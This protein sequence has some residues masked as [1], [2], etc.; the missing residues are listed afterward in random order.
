MLL[1]LAMVLM[2]STVFAEV[3]EIT[4][5]TGDYINKTQAIQFTV[6]SDTY[7]TLVKIKSSK[8]T[9]G[10]DF[11]VYSDR[12]HTAI[13]SLSA[14]Q[15][16]LDANIPTII[17]NPEDDIVI[18]DISNTKS[19]SIVMDNVQPNYDSTLTITPL[20]GFYEPFYSGDIN[21]NFTLFDD[22]KT[23]IDKFIVYLVQ[24]S[25]DSNYATSFTK[26]YPDANTISYRV[27]H[28]ISEG[29]PD[30]NYYLLV[31]AN[32]IAG[33]YCAPA[34]VLPKKKLIYIDNNAP[35]LL[36]VNLGAIDNNKIYTDKNVFDLN[37]TLRDVSGIK[38][39][40]NMTI[41]LPNG[42]FNYGTLLGSSFFVS[43]SEMSQGLVGHTVED[44][45]VFRV[46][47]DA[48]DNV[49]NRYLY[50]FNIIYDGT[51]PT[52]PNKNSLEIE[53]RD[54]NVTI[55]WGAGASTDSGSGL[56]EYRVY[57]DTSNLICVTG[58]TT[59]ECEDNS[60]KELDETL[61]YSLVAVDKAGNISD[62]N[63]QSIWTGPECD[64]TINDG[65][66][67]T[68]TPTVTI[69]ISYSNDVNEVAFSCNGSS[70]SSYE[71]LDDDDE[72]DTKTF[73][74]TSGSG[75][76]SYNEEKTIY[77]RVKSK[78]H[79][80]RTSICSSEI[81][82]DTVAPT[83]PTNVKATTQS[84][85]A[86]RISWNESE[87]ENTNSDITYKLYYS[88]ENDVTSSSPFFETESTS[89]LHTLNKDV[90]IY[91]RVSATDEVGNESAL[92]SVV[93]GTARKIGA[94]LTITITP[95]NKINDITY[96]GTGLKTIKYV[97]DESLSLAPQVSV[98]QGTDPFVSVGT[99]YDNSTRAGESD[100]NFT[101]SGAGVVRI[102]A[103][104]NS[105]ETS[106]SELEFVIDTN[107][108]SFD[109]EHTV[110]GAIFEF[111]ITGY[112]QDIYRVQ[113]LLDN[114]DELCL[115]S[116]ADTNFNCVYDSSARP[117]GNK[118]IT[119]TVYD[120]ALNYVTK[121]F[122]I[123]VDNIDEDRVLAT[124]LKDE[125]DANLSQIESDF[126]L[127]LALGLLSTLDTTVQ[128]KLDL[129][130]VSKA[131][132][133]KLFSD[134]NYSGAKE[135]YMLAKD[136]LQEISQKLPAITIET[137]NKVAET[138]YDAN[139]VLPT[140]T[141]NDANIL[142]DTNALYATKSISVTR[143]FDVIKI[144]TQKFFSVTLILENASSSARTVTVI[145]EIP[146]S[147]SKGIEDLS[148]TGMVFVLNKD[149]VVSFVAT[150]PANGTKQL[151]Y[152]FMKPVT[153]VDS[154]TK[155]NVIKNNFTPSIV[156]DGNVTTEKIIV[157]KTVDKNVFIYLILIIVLFII[158]LLIINAV[159]THKNKST[160]VVV[161]PDA[162]ADMAKYLGVIKENEGSE[163]SEGGPET[164][165]KKQ[166]SPDTYQENYDYILSAIKK[167]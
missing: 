41:T 14:T 159:I 84:S 89:Y 118:L 42:H 34:D 133:D 162:K 70:F 135:E 165:T 4:I 32:D 116:K 60:E 99:T 97:S 160:K 55:S 15:S 124:Q 17:S 66:D 117:D 125:L 45:D 96:V 30:G 35:T 6:K 58:I 21:L 166:Q 123:V 163:K 12:N 53:D 128:T 137:T 83:V 59:Y 88:L 143:N 39:G 95:S 72:D 69:D 108:P 29:I 36:S 47:L 10:V 156:L 140:G 145:E 130:K 112:P 43:M 46:A 79:T 9:N 105:N 87:D 141:V 62:A 121:E 150:I 114:A 139:T 152:R 148:F 167:R 37:V 48:N 75:C 78:E 31:D 68:K 20:G 129:A 56:K 77:A 91:Y 81:Y 142:R 146:K 64:I 54:K 127:F 110:Q 158:V 115:K 164:D 151:T 82:Y 74:I 38:Q 134:T 106:T 94:D 93:V 144:G 51:P 104:N 65:N 71:A 107:L 11:N 44:G 18:S 73:N 13:V 85:G 136:L 33:N 103:K 40:S 63:V 92:S 26:K 119:I 67:F 147:F 111:K 7:P 28:T 109:H 86:V 1:L 57:R 5:T 80:D 98:K 19:D 149:P 49:D 161:K 25:A 155:Y 27:I 138:V 50:D 154:V 76:N 102:I 157:K 8:D 61:Y 23:Y 131:D 22:N 2:T 120:T 132:G 24:V 90:N 113:Y 126:E 3:T 153:D 101:K 16:S 122:T 100:F 52:K